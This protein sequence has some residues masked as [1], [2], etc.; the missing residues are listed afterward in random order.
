MLTKI[1]TQQ[2]VKTWIRPYSQRKLDRITEGALN[3]LRA[4]GYDVSLRRVWLRNGKDQLTLAWFV[5]DEM[6]VIEGDFIV[7][8][9][10]DDL[11]VL[12]M[13]KE[14]MLDE[15]DVDGRFVL[16]EVVARCKV[17]RDG[18][19]LVIT[20]TKSAQ[21]VLGNV[22]CRFIDFDLTDC[23]GKVTIKIFETETSACRLTSTLP[24]CLRRWPESVLDAATAWRIG[25]EPFM[26]ALEVA[27]IPPHCDKQYDWN[28]IRLYL[29]N[30]LMIETADMRAELRRREKLSL[31]THWRLDNDKTQQAQAGVPT[32][33]SPR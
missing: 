3:S 16:G 19:S 24:E 14:S 12:D 10:T 20:I 9:L 8:C 27:N 13:A 23:P 11:G 33:I 4:R 29:V 2:K 7:F 28:M 1:K 26:Q 25:I 5:K 6:R 32:A 22:A 17:R 15:R 31:L 18:G 21:A 30:K